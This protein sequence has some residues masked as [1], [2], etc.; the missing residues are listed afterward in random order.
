MNNFSKEKIDTLC[1]EIS[2]CTDKNYH[3]ESLIKL[4]EFLHEHNIKKALNAVLTLHEY[5]GHLTSELHEI[6]TDLS[7]RL[8]YQL[9]H[10]ESV[11]Q[12]NKEK[13]K[14]SF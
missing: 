4:A 1:K 13:I 8:F 12:E 14:R 5:E 2:Y 3:T 10:S 6:R 7:G 9:E 11:S